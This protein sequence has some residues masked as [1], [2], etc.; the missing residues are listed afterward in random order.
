MKMRS[1]RLM[2][3]VAG[4]VAAAIIGKA[5]DHPQFGRNPNRNNVVESAS[6]PP[7][8]DIETGENIKWSRPLGS[9][10]YGS[11]VVAGGKVFVGTNNAASYLQRYPK[12]VDLGVLLCFREA[13]GK[14]LWQHSSEKLP[15]GRIH[16]WPQQ[17]VGS[18]PVVEGDRLWYVTNR[19]EVVCLDA[20]GFLDNEDD[21]SV[22]GISSRP[23]EI[24]GD[25]EGLKQ[26]QNP[27]DFTNTLD[28]IIEMA[29]IKVSDVRTY[30]PTGNA[31]SWMATAVRKKVSVELFQIDAGD[32]TVKISGRGEF[33]GKNIEFDIDLFKGLDEGHLSPALNV[34]FSSRGIELPDAVVS[35]VLQA[36]KSWSVP[37]TRQGTASELRIERFG[38]MLRCSQEIA[39]AQNEADIIWSFDMMRELGVSQHNMANCSPTI[40]GDVLFVCTSNGV[41][42]THVHIPAPDAPSFLALDKRTGAVLWTDNSPGKNILHGQW[43][44]PAVGVFDGV[45]QVLF[46][47]GDG[48]LYSFRADAGVNG[49]PEFLWKFDGNPKDSTYG[50]SGK[51]TRNGV[52]APPVI[53][54]GLVYLTMGEDPERGEG[55]G[56][57]WCITPTRQ[58]DV[59]P[60]LVVDHV[61]HS[62]PH[63]RLKA[64]AP[65]GSLQP[66]AISNPN[67]ALVWHYG[68]HDFSGNGA[69]EFAEQFHRSI[70]GPAI[71]EDLL[72]ITDFSGLA[73]CVHA[74]TGTPYWTADLFGA[75]WGGTLIVGDQACVGDEDGDITFLNLSTDPARSVVV[76][77][78]GFT[79]LPKREIIG[80][81]PIYST[82]TFANGVLYIATKDRLFAIAAKK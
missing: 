38:A 73:H 25:L 5:S 40:W 53:Y 44:S 47:G 14:F 12:N 69:I 45:A 19:G 82:P 32:S 20:E 64:T 54:D 34:Q 24:I 46:A 9:Q 29:G 3:I 35:K 71:K 51:S 39:P 36:G 43:S 4:T 52:I 30:R 31:S 75:V 58:G 15:T 41:D 67:S 16:D 37:I 6:L 72:L 68:S 80:G 81:S 7:S 74:K 28:R 11:P 65:V 8:W 27:F 66:T 17:G 21:G 10:T 48:W 26:G 50:V 70:G 62:I 49:K 42:E 2:V 60:Q 77:R 59:S 55:D 76:A 18:T 22:I 57:L 1:L 78:G 56:H 79:G 61:G 23:F 63:Q 13:D 33:T